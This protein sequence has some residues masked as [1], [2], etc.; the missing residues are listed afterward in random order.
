MTY[1]NG[2]E[3]PMEEPAPE[4]EPEPEPEPKAEEVKPEAEEKVLEDM[5]E[6]APSPVPVESPPNTQEPAKVRLTCAHG[7]NFFVIFQRNIKSKMY[8]LLKQ[9]DIIT[10]Y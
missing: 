10:L 1:S 6:K 4:P 3:E 5:E 9:L 2:V 7:I 8:T